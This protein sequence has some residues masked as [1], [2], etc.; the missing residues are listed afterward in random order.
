VLSKLSKCLFDVFNIVTHSDNGTS[1]DLTIQMN[2]LGR[3]K[4]IKIMEL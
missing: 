1:L 3:T 4:A 2:C